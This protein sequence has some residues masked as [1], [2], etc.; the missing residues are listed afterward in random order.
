V[1]VSALRIGLLDTSR[2]EQPGSMREYADTLQQA[3]TRHAKRLQVETF[4]VTSAPGRGNWARRQESV[5]M[6]REAWR[7]RNRPV[8]VWHILDGRRAYIGLALG[9]QPLVITAHDIIPHLQAKGQFPEAPPMGLAAR[10]LWRAN[11][12]ATRTAAAVACDSTATQRD[13]TQHFSIPASRCAVVPLPLRQSL[14]RHLPGPHAQTEGAD[15]TGIVLH[16]GSNAFYKNR[17]Q[18]LR[19]FAALDARFALRLVMI[20]PPP[21]ASLLALADHLELADRVH[22]VGDCD[23]ATV[24][25][26]YQKASLML[27]PSLYEGYGWPVLEAMAFGLPV[28][29][30]AAGSLPELVG[31]GADSP[32]AADLSRWV[33]EANQ[34]LRS[35]AAHAAASAAG[36][37]RA[38]TFTAQRLVDEMQAIYQRVVQSPSSMTDRQ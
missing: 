37:A 24:A 14:I 4:N 20:G 13:L 8:D 15:Q 35:P 18:V 36:L 30:A 7:L 2:P 9:H 38:N 21:T 11:R 23:D 10:M 25:E 12:T 27:F 22:W 32:A 19:I 6:L 3:L 29:A 28:I 34:L 5:A 16:V 31:D 26:W 33:A 1:T 17:P